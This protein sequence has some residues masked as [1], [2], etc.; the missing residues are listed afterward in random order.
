MLTVQNRWLESKLL[1]FLDTSP[2]SVP[3]MSK[4]LPGTAPPEAAPLFAA[5]E[6]GPGALGRDCAPTRAAWQIS[7]SP[8]KN[9]S[10]SPRNGRSC[11]ACRKRSHAGPTDFD[12]RDWS[13]YPADCICP[14]G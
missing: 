2:K 8:K 5:Q 3:Q 11:A 13:R 10:S 6:S 1:W 4:F 14:I 7:A 12:R 9:A